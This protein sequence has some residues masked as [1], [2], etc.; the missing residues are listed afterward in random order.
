MDTWLI[1][2]RHYAIKQGYMSAIMRTPDGDI[3]LILLTIRT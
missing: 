3:F 2:Y 1:L